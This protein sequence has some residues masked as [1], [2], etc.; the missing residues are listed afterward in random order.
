MNG[1][2]RISMAAMV[3]CA[4][5][6]ALAEEPRKTWELTPE[7]KVRLSPEGAALP[8]VPAKTPTTRPAGSTVAGATESQQPTQQ[9]APARRNPTLDRVEALLAE[10]KGS[11]AHDELLPWLLGNPTAADYDRG[12]LLMA[13]AKVAT[14]DPIRAFYYCDQLMDERGD[15]SLFG[16]ALQKQYDIADA[17]LRGEKET[18]LGIPIISRTDTGIAMLFR[19]QERAPGSPVSEAAALRM[20]DHYWAG[21]EWDLAADAYGA[22]ARTYPR[23]PKATPARLREAYANLAQVRGP[24]FDPTPV[25]NARA[26]LAELVATNPQLAEQESL[27]G[28]IELADRMLARKLYLGAEYYQRVGKPDSAA[29]LYQRTIELY[30]QLPEADDAR[31]KLQA[32]NPN[33]AT[34][35]AGK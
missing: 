1:L 13:D 34:T 17:F 29:W 3:A 5:V 28:K 7:N 15:S 6:S 23:N 35:E 20:A 4:S 33:V 11:Q 27:V 9:V 31:K 25:L 10:G 14:G 12:L 19:I 32:V 18:F 2:I 26:T 16:N 30:P 21:G 22:F 8:G 24:L